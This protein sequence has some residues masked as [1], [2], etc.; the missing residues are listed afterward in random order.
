MLK[1]LRPLGPVAVSFVLG[2]SLLGTSTSALPV[3]T[4]VQSSVNL[5]SASP[6]RAAAGGMRVAVRT[7]VVAVPFRTLTRYSNDIAGG[8]SQLI[9]TGRWGRAAVTVWTSYR[10][11]RVF[12]REPIGRRIITPPV[13]AILVTGSRPTDPAGGIEHGQ[14]SWYRCPNEGDFAA[15]LQIPKGTM[16]TVTNPDNGR[17]V[18]V[19]IDDRGPYGI[20][21]RIIDLC[22]SAFAKIAPLGQGVANVEIRW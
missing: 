4:A 14:A 11:G 18:T 22:S 21:G 6:G 9:R 20:P 12:S 7:V 17:N 2:A 15:Q 5:R 19:I 16:V 8:E 13:D 1:R 10:N 3:D